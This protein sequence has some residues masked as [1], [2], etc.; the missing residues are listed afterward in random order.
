MTVLTPASQE[1]K[2]NRIFRT[3]DH[4]AGRKKTE[5]QKNSYKNKDLKGQCMGHSK[6]MA[7]V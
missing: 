5:K 2:T 3:S 7:G 4:T 1:K 6:I